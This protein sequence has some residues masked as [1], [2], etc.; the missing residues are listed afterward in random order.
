MLLV[1]QGPDW[2]GGWVWPVPDIGD[3]DPP[4]DGYAVISNHFSPPRHKGVDIMYRGA[5]SG[6]YAPVGTPTA[7]ARDGTVWS[8]GQTARGWGVVVDHGP[9][10]ATFYQ[11]LAAVEPG[12]AKGAAVKAG[13]RLGTMG[14]DP[15][16]PERV[17]HLHFEVWWRGGASS[18]VDPAPMLAGA[19]RLLWTP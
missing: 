7:A 18:A 4:A 19:R 8:V 5:V 10:F 11:H 16:D 9:P 13:Q 1:K 15:T 17:R 14:V 12:I 3:I 2:G 6:Y